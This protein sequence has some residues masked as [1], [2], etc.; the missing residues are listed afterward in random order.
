MQACLLI[1][2]VPTGSI[3]MAEHPCVRLRP[4]AVR[5]QLSGW[6]IMEG[7]IPYT[8]LHYLTE[9]GC[10]WDVIKFDQ[11]ENEKIIQKAIASTKNE[12]KATIQS[13]RKSYT[14]SCARFSD[15]SMVPEDALKKYDT[16]TKATVKRLKQTLADLR[17][18]AS[19]FGIGDKDLN[20]VD[21]FQQVNA[22]QASIAEK[23]KEYSRV[24][25]ELAKQRG[26]NDGMVRM[27]RADQVPA[28]VLA[29]YAEEHGV[30][31]TAKLRNMFD[32]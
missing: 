14:D 2:D 9:K 24:V 15:G 32:F 26:E 3:P 17:K 7:N 28:G 18:A 25:N 6:V 27:A 20:V 31:G 10:T 23:A 11:A 22:L 4:I 13:A 12:I 19:T 21:A 5:L 16:N 29:D 30:K 1:Y 8:Y